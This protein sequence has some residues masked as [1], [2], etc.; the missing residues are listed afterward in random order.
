MDTLLL[1]AVKLLCFTKEVAS[2]KPAL[3]SPLEHCSAGDTGFDLTFSHLLAAK[4]EKTRCVNHGSRQI[5]VVDRKRRLH[6]VY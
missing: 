2:S 6:S 3:S 4:M 5:S 1:S